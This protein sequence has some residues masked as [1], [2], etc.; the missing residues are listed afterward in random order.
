MGLSNKLSCEAQSF[1]CRLNPHRFFQSEILR[2]YFHAMELWVSRSVWLPSCSSRFICTQI[3]DHSLH[4]LP[5]CSASS[6]SE[7][8]VSCPLT[9]VDECFFFNSLIVRLLYSSIFCQFWL[10]LFL[11]LLLSFF[12]LCEEVKH[13]YLC[14]CL[15]WIPIFNFLR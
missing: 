13:I 7:L 4:Q 12:W 14:P 11:N 3:W 1:S 9:G 15:G 8:P 2:L 6:P 5:L 10:F